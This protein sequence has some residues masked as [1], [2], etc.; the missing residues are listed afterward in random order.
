MIKSSPEALDLV[1]RI[2]SCHT[3]DVSLGGIKLFVDIDI[4]CG[5]ILE[6]EIIFSNSPERYWLI[7]NVIWCDEYVDESLEGDWYNIG[8]SFD[9][10][11]NPQ[12]SSWGEAILELLSRGW[13]D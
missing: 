2:F 6:L 7:G 3:K 5:A 10:A 8:V 4:P 11:E 13:E 9:V 1:G 12:F